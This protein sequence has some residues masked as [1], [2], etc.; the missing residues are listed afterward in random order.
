MSSLIRRKI[1]NSD[2]IDTYEHTPDGGSSTTH[3][4][5]GLDFAISNNE[6]FVIKSGALDG[7]GEGLEIDSSGNVTATANFTVSGTTTTLSASNMVVSDQL[8]ELGNG[9]SGSASGDAGIVIERGDDDNQFMGFDESTDRFV[10]GSGSFTGASTG[11]LDITK[12]AIDA[13]LD[14]VTNMTIGASIPDGQTI[15][16]GPSGA[17][18][19]VFTPHG[20]AGSE[21]ISI[22]NTSGDAADAISLTSA[23]GGVDID[24]AAAKDVNIAGG[25]V[26]LVSKDDAASAISLTANQG[27]SETIVLTNTQGTAEG[28]I[29]LTS[30][31]GG[32]DIDAAAAKDVNI[33]GGQVALVSKDD[34]AS[35]ISL[36]TNQGSSET[37]VVTNTQGTAAAAINFEASAGGILA[38]ADGDIADAI[39]LHATAGTSQTITVL[40]TAGTSEGAITLTSTAGGVDIDAAAAKD[41]NIAGG[42]VALVSKDDA[43]SAISLTANQGS[44]ETIVVTNTQ[45]TDNA[46]IA[47]TST[48][49]GVKIDAGKADAAAITLDASN[50]AG[51]VNIDFGT[52]GLNAASDTGAANAASGTL[53]LASGTGGVGSG[54]SAAG[55]S[56]AISITSGAGG[57][58]GAGGNAGAS[59][60]ITIATGAGGAGTSN[61]RDGGNSG[62]INITCGAAGTKNGS[63]SDGTQGNINLTANEIDLVGKFLLGGVEVTATAA[64]LNSAGGAAGGA[65]SHTNTADSSATAGG[66]L[67]LTSDDSAF[68]ASGHQLGI[69]HFKGSTDDSNSVGTGAQIKAIAEADFDGSTNTSKLEF[70]TTNGTTTSAALTLAGSNAATFASSVSSTEFITTSD[71]RLKKNIKDIESPLNRILKLRGIHFDWIDTEKY[72]S[73][74]NIGFLAQEVEAVF[75]QLVSER[76][77][78]KA[79]NYAQTTAVLVEAI[80]EQNVII[81]DLKEEIKNVKLALAASIKKNNKKL[82]TETSKKTKKNTKTTSKTTSKTKKDKNQS[83]MIEFLTSDDNDTSSVNS[84]S[85]ESTKAPL[86]KRKTN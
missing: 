86:K 57:A 83:E 18:Q 47:L 23:A 38:S 37:I 22:T 1:N 27:S 49:G 8:I 31:A 78:I 53:T 35:A 26:A 58:G 69:I 25:Q 28:A 70:H 77:N 11:N 19:M 40:N 54:S 24:A 61:D 15:T 41:V 85:D 39:K 81:L 17:T 50:A 76:D 79:V 48:A 10:F 67:T 16:I 30:T 65:L 59:G 29:T 51:G 75:P 21:K 7:S 60:S 74:N 68:L 64:Q 14:S 46:A 4:H 82:D 20:T 66:S 3:F 33:A 43:A 71:K 2:A 63:G 56:G 52:G 72:G 44:S 13:N 45:G 84:S 42:Q 62:D 32:V 12:G 36:T 73:K 5:T 34:A 80:K 9:R 6:K 55:A